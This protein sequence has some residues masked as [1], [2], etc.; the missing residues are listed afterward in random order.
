MSPGTARR[1][2]RIHPRMPTK[3]RHARCLRPFKGKVDSPACEPAGARENSP[4]D[5]FLTR[6]LRIHPRSDTAK[7]RYLRISFLLY[8]GRWI[9]TTEG[10]ASRFTVCPLWPLGNSP[11]FFSH[12]LSPGALVLYHTDPGL[13][14]VFSW[15]FY[16]F[17][18]T[19]DGWTS[20]LT[21]RKHYGRC[22]SHRPFP[23]VVPRIRTCAIHQIRPSQFLTNSSV[24]AILQSADSTNKT[25]RW[26]S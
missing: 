20:L 6:A 2:L 19:P 8:G 16:F 15:K 22:L 12:G 1:A 25:R 17:A 21:D 13:S 10:G 3:K 4:P 14:R 23:H 9:R 24:C 5:C 11:L 18:R 26:F 7:K